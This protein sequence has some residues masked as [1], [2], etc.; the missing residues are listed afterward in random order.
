M[1]SKFTRERRYIVLKLTDVAAANLSPGET[2]FFNDMCDKISR[3]RISQGKGL[4]ECVVV[5]KD[6]PEY[7]S[8]W[9]AIENRMAGA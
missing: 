7:G 5:E 4:L 6:W 2:A 3:A 1:M 8:T 9:K